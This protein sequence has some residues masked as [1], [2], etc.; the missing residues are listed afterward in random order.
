[1]P[2]KDAVEVE[3]HSCVQ[4]PRPGGPKHLYRVPGGAVQVCSQFYAVQP[5]TSPLPA[6]S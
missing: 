5:H 4:V 3:F 1:M 2:I 6:D